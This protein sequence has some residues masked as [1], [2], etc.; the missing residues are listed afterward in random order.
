MFKGCVSEKKNFRY[1]GI[2][3]TCQHFSFINKFILDLFR[4]LGFL[5]LFFHL[6][7]SAI[8]SDSLEPLSVLHSGLNF[9]W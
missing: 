6:N 7:P 2:M 8:D 5:T 3:V 4:C 1:K 9:E